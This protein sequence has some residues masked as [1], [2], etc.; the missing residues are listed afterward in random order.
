MLND[1]PCLRVTKTVNGRRYHLDYCR[2]VAAVAR[3]V[4]LGDLVEV[5]PFPD[6]SASRRLA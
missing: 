6:K 5:I 4:D 3:H 1:R 2:D